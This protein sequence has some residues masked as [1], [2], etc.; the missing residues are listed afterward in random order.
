[1]LDQNIIDEIVDGAVT[2]EVCLTSVFL[3]YETD[4]PLDQLDYHDKLPYMRETWR[5]YLMEWLEEN[6]QLIEVALE[7]YNEC[8]EYGA[9]SFGIEVAHKILDRG[10]DFHTEKSVDAEL[11]DRLDDSLD[12]YWCPDGMHEIWWENSELHIHRWQ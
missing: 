11:A 6:E 9:Y 12:G 8:Y 7:E 5:A 1:M 4:C 3:D 2:N 10:R